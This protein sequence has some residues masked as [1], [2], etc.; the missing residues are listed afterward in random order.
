MPALCL[1]WQK[2]FCFFNKVD[3]IEEVFRK[4]DSI[5]NSQ[6]LEIANEV[7]CPEKLLSL[8]YK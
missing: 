8:I 5:T 2:V 6:L 4:I 7:L 1:R 3:T